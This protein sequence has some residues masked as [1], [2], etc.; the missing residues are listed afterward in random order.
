[1]IEGAYS[2]VIPAYRAVG[3]IGETIASILSQSVPPHQIIVVDDG[4]PDDTAGAVRTIAGPIVYVRQ[5]N[6]GPGGATTRGFS[7]VETEFVATLDQDDLWLPHKAERQL[8]RLRAAP[9]L[10]GVFG[11]VTQFSGSPA[12]A[13]LNHSHEGWTRAT[14]VGAVDR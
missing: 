14:M 8:A 2:V 9:E 7:M 11:R 1:M 13:N 4:S 5:E 3:L 10:A 12:S 6:T